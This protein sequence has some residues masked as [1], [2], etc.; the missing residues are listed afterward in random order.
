M[1]SGYILPVQATLTCGTANIGSGFPRSGLTRTPSMSVTAAGNNAGTIYIHLQTGGTVPN[2]TP[3]QMG[4]QMIPLTAGQSFS[5]G[6]MERG[7]GSVRS[8]TF[9][10]PYSFILGSAAGQGAVI[11]YCKWDK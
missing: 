2:R 10:A 4:N 8:I 3:T 9:G 5:F 6:G 11:T 1:S 7:N